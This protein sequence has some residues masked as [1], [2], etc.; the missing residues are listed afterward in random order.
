VL[1]KVGICYLKATI[2]TLL[3]VSPFVKAKYVDSKKKRT[4]IKVKKRKQ[5][6][7]KRLREN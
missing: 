4:D 6:K 5:K 1:K 7:K 3:N 2:K